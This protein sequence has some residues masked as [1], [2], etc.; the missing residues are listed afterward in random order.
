MRDRSSQKP[1]SS[2]KL[3]SGI[4]ESTDKLTPIFSFEKMRDRSGH[5]VNCCGRDD[6]AAL[7]RQMYALSQLTWD[8]IKKAPKHG[9]GSETISNTALKVA[10]PSSITPDVTL[11]AFRYNAKAPFLGY[12]EG[13]IFYVLLIDHNFGCY[14]H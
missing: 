2:G 10:L 13:R 11:L 9:L 7:A 5:S 1:F 4:T 3:G 8:E 12:R 14:K 6:Q